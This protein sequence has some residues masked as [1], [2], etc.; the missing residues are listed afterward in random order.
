MILDNKQNPTLSQLGFPAMSLLFFNYQGRP[1]IIG[2][3][4]EM[5]YV[6]M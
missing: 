6:G 3:A 5:I 2:E 1:N 4:T